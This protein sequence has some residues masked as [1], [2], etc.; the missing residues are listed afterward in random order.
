MGEKKGETYFNVEAKWERRDTSEEY[1]FQGNF[2]LAQLLQV[3]NTRT[4]CK[5]TDDPPSYVA[6]Y[7]HFV[8]LVFLFKYH[9]G[10]MLL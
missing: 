2:D 10:A 9:K 5:K 7:E 6:N 8:D 1:Y 3:L 4:K